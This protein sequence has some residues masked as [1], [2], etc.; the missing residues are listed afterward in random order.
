MHILTV[1]VH[2]KP[3][4]LE[5]FKTATLENAA[6]TRKEPLAVRFDVLQQP[7]DPTRF[8]LLEIYRNPEGHAQ[9]RNTPHYTAWAERVADMLAEPRTRTIYRNFDPADENW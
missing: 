1:Y 3:E 5:S 9:H 8:M 6:A 7:D 2:V 4:H